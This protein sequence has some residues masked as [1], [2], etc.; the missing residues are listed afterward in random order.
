MPQPHVTRA[1]VMA[2]LLALPSS[3]VRRIVGPSSCRAFAFSIL[4]FF[5]PR[6]TFSSKS[7]LFAAGLVSEVD[8]EGLFATFV[9]RLPVGEKNTKK[10]KKV[11]L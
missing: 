3:V 4:G 11:R 9:A 1:A 6:I 5:T 2:W 7:S 8:R 10:S